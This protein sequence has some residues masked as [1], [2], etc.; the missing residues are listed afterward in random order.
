VNT[1]TRRWLRRFWPAVVAVL[2]LLVMLGA[3][4]F[5]TR[6]D[7]FV[8][9]A[10]GAELDCRYLVFTFSQATV[11]HVISGSD[12]HWVVTAVGTVLNPNDEALSPIGGDYGQ[13]VFRDDASGQTAVPSVVPGTLGGDARRSDVVPGAAPISIEVQAEFDNIYAPGATV[14]FAVAK[15]EYTENI[16]LGLG[17]GD[18]QWNKDSFEPLYLLNLPLAQ[19]PEER[20]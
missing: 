20:S 8:P 19:L 18:K 4:G 7:R 6:T 5:T 17:G 11:K 16:V 14:T 12:Q 15:A 2:A 10:A 3:G 1:G 13:F 9:A